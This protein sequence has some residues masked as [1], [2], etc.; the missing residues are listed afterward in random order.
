M[1]TLKVAIVTKYY[2][3]VC[4]HIHMHV[5]YRFKVCHKRL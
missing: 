5:Q 2:R 3:L 4:A 1:R